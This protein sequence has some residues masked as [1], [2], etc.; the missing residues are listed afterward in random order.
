M[1]YARFRVRINQI[2]SNQICKANIFAYESEQHNASAHGPSTASGVEQFMKRVIN[3]AASSVAGASTS[4]LLIRSL[5]IEALPSG[6]TLLNRV[7]SSERRVT[8]ALAPV[9]ALDSHL[10]AGLF[11]GER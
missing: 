5:A 8:T 7:L 3:V 10:N 4:R 11:H 2:K 1:G 9:R 6:V